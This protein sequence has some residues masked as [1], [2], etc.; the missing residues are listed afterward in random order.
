MS[1]EPVHKIW[2]TLCCW[3]AVSTTVITLKSNWKHATLDYPDNALLLPKC[4][5]SRNI[6]MHNMMTAF[7]GSFTMSGHSWLRAHIISSAGH[8]NFSPDA[9]FFGTKRAILPHFIKKVEENRPVHLLGNRP[10]T[11]TMHQCHHGTR[12]HWAYH[13]SQPGYSHETQTHK[14]SR[15][16]VATQCHRHHSSTSQRLRLQLATSRT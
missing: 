16:K 8:N 11:R 1:K 13:H 15:I 14:E 3:H 9:F 6:M 2:P 7:G 10:K 4:S 12:P 5:R